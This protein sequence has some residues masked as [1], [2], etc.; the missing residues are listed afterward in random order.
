MNLYKC[1]HPVLLFLMKAQR[2]Q[3]FRILNSKPKLKGNVIYAM[4]HSAK[5]DAPIATELIQEHVWILVGRQR[6]KVV[7]RICF[8]LNGVIWVDRKKKADRLSAK[9]CLRDKY[10]IPKQYFCRI[11]ATCRNG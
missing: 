1:L 9:M 6:L 5:D 3:E 2:K 10:E 4:N 7:D 8:L 11:P